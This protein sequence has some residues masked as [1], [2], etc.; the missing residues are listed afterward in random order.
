MTGGGGHFDRVAGV[1][2]DSLPAHVVEHYLEKR[3]RFI[4]AAAPAPARLLDV[5]CGTGTLAMR[6][7]E[8]GYDVTGLDPSEGML[9]VMRERAPRIPSACA[10]ATSMPFAEAE[11]DVAVSV[12]TMHHIADPAAVRQA[13]TEMVRVVRPGGTIV[14]W[15][16][17]PRNPYWPYLMRRVPQD[18][19]D[20]RLVGA[21]ELVAGLEA[22]GAVVERNVTMGLVPD[23]V[24]PRALAL[25]RRVE[26]AVERLPGMRRL[27]A[28]NVVVAH[29]P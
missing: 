8:R 3:A 1:Y 14:V 28:H 20:E 27:C 13:L 22:G 11:F 4:A 2:D 6:L 9:S 29:R 18:A 12:A 10:S 17:N 21:G 25:A 5:G 24:P 19:G 26:A 15:D 23:F 16:H 7:A